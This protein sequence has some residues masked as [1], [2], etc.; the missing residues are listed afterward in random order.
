MAPS[1]YLKQCWNIVNWTLGNKFQWNFSRNSN[2]FIEENTFENVVCKMLFISSR[3][4]CVNIMIMETLSDSPFGN[5]LRCL[6]ANMMSLWC[7][8]NRF[9]LSL[10]RKVITSH[11][12]SFIYIMGIPN[13]EILHLYLKMDHQFIMHRF[14]STDGG[15][16]GSNQYSIIIYNI[17]SDELIIVFIFNWHIS[18]PHIFFRQII[19]ISNR[20]PMGLFGEKR[21]GRLRH[22][23]VI[24]ST[25]LYGR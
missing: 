13:L 25:I 19:E 23:E 18:F 4:Q 10:Q 14:L 12:D 2:I 9:R 15:M 21:L 7:R 1:H 17:T 16:L 5:Y 22:G 8:S 24:T 6:K 11:Q 20:R 3:P